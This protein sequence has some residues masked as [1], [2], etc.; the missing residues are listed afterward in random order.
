MIRNLEVADIIVKLILA[1]LMIVL[2][3]PRVI[4]GRSAMVLLVLVILIVVIFT[5]RIVL[6]FIT[7]D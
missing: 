6:M 5:F 1:V 4:S 2:Y 3:F 7:R